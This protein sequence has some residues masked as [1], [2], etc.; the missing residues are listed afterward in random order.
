MRMASAQTKSHTPMV[1]RS[2]VY[3]PENRNEVFCLE[4]SDGDIVT[5]DAING[6]VRKQE[7]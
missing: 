3:I 1:I 5:V 2:C 6:I 7:S 4:E